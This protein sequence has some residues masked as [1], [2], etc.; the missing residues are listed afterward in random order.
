MRVLTKEERDWIEWYAQAFDH[1]ETRNDVVSVEP[2]V[3]ANASAMGI[4][5]RALADLIIQRR[6][7]S[8]MTKDR[9][10]E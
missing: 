3:V 4:E 7:A 8:T 2:L 9:Y 6:R 1:E 5:K 10:K